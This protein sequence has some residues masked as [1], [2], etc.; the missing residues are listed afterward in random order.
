MVTGFGL[1]LGSGFATLPGELGVVPAEGASD[2]PFVRSRVEPGHLL[3]VEAVVCMM[4]VAAGVDRPHG[5]GRPMPG[6]T[7]MA[8][9]GEQ[10]A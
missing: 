2:P 8:A 6:G 3:F 5:P 9:V 7:G 4:A 1:L 10:P